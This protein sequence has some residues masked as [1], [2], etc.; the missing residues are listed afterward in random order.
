MHTPYQGG[1]KKV[2]R[3]EQFPPQHFEHL[4][5]CCGPDSLAEI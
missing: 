1:K 3:E 4:L 5:Q 2:D